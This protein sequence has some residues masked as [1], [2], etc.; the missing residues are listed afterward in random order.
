MFRLHA[1]LRPRVVGTAA[2]LGFFALSF[3][4]CKSPESPDGDLTGRIIAANDCG[5][6]VDI[7]MDGVFKLFLDD[8][9]KFDVASVN[10]GSYFLEAKLKDTETVVRAATIDVVASAEFYFIIEGPSTLSITNQYGE[11][12]K[13]YMDEEYLGDIGSDLTQTVRKFRFGTHELEAKRRSDGETV[14]SASIEVNEIKEYTWTIV[15]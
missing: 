1:R 9:T 12:L 7:Y 15:K 8:K 14:A 10:L 6:T 4:N 3:M 13:I 5:A 2:L 11:I